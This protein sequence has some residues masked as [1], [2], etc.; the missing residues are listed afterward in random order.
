VKQAKAD[1]ALKEEK[2]K[3]VSADTSQK[4]GDLTDKSIGPQTSKAIPSSSSGSK[5]TEQKAPAVAVPSSSS[6]AS[7]AASPMKKTT[8][9]AP[10]EDKAVVASPSSTSGS[11]KK[12]TSGLPSASPTAISRIVEKDL[13]E[14]PKTLYE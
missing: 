7:S 9:A 1:Q 5:I 2:S 4:K 14:P 10:E 11:K 12:S 6:A 3:K 8:P 13:Q